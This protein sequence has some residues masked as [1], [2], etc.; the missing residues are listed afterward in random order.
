MGRLIILELVL[1]LLRLVSFFRPR[2]DVAPKGKPYLIRWY[3][4]PAGKGRFAKWY[5]RHLPGIFL[6]CFLDSDPDRGWHSHPWKWA[7]S[8][9]LKGSYIESRPGPPM[10]WSDWRDVWTRLDP[11]D[12]NTLRIGDYHKVKLLTHKVWTLF[13][14]GPLHG[15]EWAFMNEKGE[16]SHHGT[17]TP[18]D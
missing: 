18:G 12:V 10:P 15:G 3:L 2:L 17:D 14:V 7:K 4:T 5:R 8:L 11:G 1:A 13:V 6:H 9:I 16:V